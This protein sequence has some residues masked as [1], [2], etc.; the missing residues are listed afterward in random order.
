MT[1]WYYADAAN[2]RQGPVTTAALLQLRQQGAI[3]EETL[4]WREGLDGW[5]PLRTL[6]H[7]FK[8]DASMS[9]TADTAPAADAPPVSDAD[10]RADAQV[11]RAADA[12]LDGQSTAAAR[13][14]AA[15]PVMDTI[16]ASPY[17]PPSA[18]LSH[19]AAVV[20]GGDVV[21]AGF[22]KRAAALLIDALLVSVV[23]YVMIFAGMMVLGIGGAMAGLGMGGA[24]SGAVAVGLIAAMYVGYP[25]ISGLYYVSMEA[26]SRQA[27][28]GKMAVGIKVTGLDGARIG[29]GRALGRWASHLINY[30]T[31]YIGYLVALFTQRKQGLH[32]MV[33]S[34]YVVDQWAYTAFPE[35]QQHKLGTVATVILVIWVALLLLGIGVL[36]LAGILSAL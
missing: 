20:Q 7:T 11:F 2:T 12:G 29:R 3:G 25:L 28:L 24:G 5:K 21:D 9:W 27:T 1:D 15:H 26:S 23:W 16:S 13:A 18:P 33:A 6:A 19:S 30:F 35:R 36:V 8:N 17:A 4:L 34:T 31:F 10:A 22:L 14:P 32:D